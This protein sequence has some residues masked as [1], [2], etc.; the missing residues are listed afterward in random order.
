M[1]DVSRGE[2]VKMVIKRR[3]VDG[4]KKTVKNS[5]NRS[6]AKKTTSCDGNCYREQTYSK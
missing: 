3:A 1:D 2:D 5:I 4:V 6:P